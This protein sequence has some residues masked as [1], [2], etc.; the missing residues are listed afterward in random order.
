MVTQYW[1]FED[2]LNVTIQHCDIALPPDSL[3][4][5]RP[6]Q[7]WHFPLDSSLTVSQNKAFSR[8]LE[9]WGS[10]HGGNS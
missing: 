4:G 2:G 6:S 3:G 10:S 1:L 9:F 7:A 5:G 8:C